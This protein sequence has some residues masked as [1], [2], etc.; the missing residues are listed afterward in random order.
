MRDGAV[1]G[2]KKKNI[3]AVHETMRAHVPKQNVDIREYR[4]EGAQCS[5]DR[6]G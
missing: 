5:N 3:S 1:G 2:G 6:D 4:T